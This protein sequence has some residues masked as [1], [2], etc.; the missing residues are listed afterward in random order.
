MSESLYSFDV[1]DT[2]IARRTATPEGIFALMQQKLAEPEHACR[3]PERIVHNF[4][5][6]RIEAEK[7]ARN[8]YI[9]E[10]VKDITL[11]QIYECFLRMED[12]SEAQVQELMVLE[13][14]VES[15]NILP[16]P[17]N[18]EKVRILKEAGERVV[19]ISNM[20]LDREVIRGLLLQASPI[21][22]DIPLYVSGELGKTKGTHTLYHH[23]K[24]QEQ[25]EYSGWRHYGDNRNLD[26]DIP[27]SLGIRAEHCARPGLLDWEKELLQGKE[28]DSELQLLLGISQRARGQQKGSAGF[29][30]QVGCGF[31]AE[32]LV[33][34]VLWVLRESRKLGLKKLCFI[35]RDGYIL[36]KIADMLI[37]GY[38]LQTE[39]AYLYGSRKAWRLPSIRPDR[40]DM[41]EFV[42]WNYPGEI[43][44]FT[45]IAEI[46]GLTIE[47][48][49]AF[50]P[51]AHGGP[52]E[53][54]GPLVRD[55]LQMLSEEQVRVAAAIYEKQREAREAAQKYLLQ[56]LGDREDIAFVDLI[57]S[58]YTQKCLADLV[59]GFHHAPIRTFFYRLDYCKSGDRNRNFAYFPNQVKMGNIIEV[60]CGAP[61][62]QTNGYERKGGAWVPILGNDEGAKLKEYGFEDYIRGIEDYVKEL[63]SCFTEGMPVFGNLEIPAAYFACLA[64]ARDRKLYDYVALM[65]YGITG[66]EREV[67]SFAPRLSDRDLRN[68]YFWHKGEPEKKYYKGYS[69]GYS[70]TCLSERQQKKLAFYRKHSEDRAVKWLRRHIFQARTKVWDSRYDMI[71]ERIVLYGAGKKGQ[72]LYRQ[73]TAG[74]RY[75]AEIVL[76]VDSNHA[77]CR[78][79][80]LQVHPPE[81]ISTVDYCQ[82][83]IAVADWKMAEEIKRSL[84]DRGVFPGKI[85]WVRPDGH[86]R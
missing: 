24:G 4:Y 59:E 46:L 13:A 72:L 42:R 60:L 35:A 30:Y 29:P 69:L 79:K 66:Q 63:I 56:E 68:L 45:Q 61:H 23:V 65:P 37:E 12:L 41:E 64:Q 71:A 9:T 80:G 27:R 48:L 26:V 67:A 47:E 19:L 77:D 81:D 33:P 8:T 21:F 31:S 14:A 11:R 51:F 39:T 53:L 25:V 20:Y 83:V 57:G 18:I 16:I 86:I 70:L 75:H 38:G 7:V 74:K 50:L 2:L 1:F 10:K 55:V 73:L 44:T 54:A 22:E 15:E 34:Y 49:K 36:K 28:N 6:L 84:A 43:S 85:L 5:L 62:G 17:E 78:A 76:W 32:I 3:Y 58:G 52:E 82:I 40:F